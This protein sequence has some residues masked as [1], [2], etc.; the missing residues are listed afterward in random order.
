MVVEGHSFVHWLAQSGWPSRLA[1]P[2]MEYHCLGQRGLTW[3]IMERNSETYKHYVNRVTALNP[4]II[5]IIMASNDLSKLNC[6]PDYCI[7][8]MH[9]FQNNIRIKLPNCIFLYVK[10]SNKYKPRRLPK[11]KLEISIRRFNRKVKNFNRKLNRWTKQQKRTGIVE[12][13]KQMR[14]KYYMADGLHHSQI[15]NKS[16]FYAIQNTILKTNKY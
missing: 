15:G 13:K 9:K 7:N 1:L 8:K 14:K 10:C 6:T 5:V 2:G 3:E 16:L 12:W 11:R 4:H